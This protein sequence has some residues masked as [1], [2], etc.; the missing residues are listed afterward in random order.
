MKKLLAIVVLS[1][2]L[3]SESAFAKRTKW[4]R[5]NFYENEIFWT[6]KLK[7]TLPP[8][9]F[10]LVERYDWSSW[11]LEAKSSDL[12]SLKN[13]VFDQMVSIGEV[14]SWTYQSYVR[15]WIYEWLYQNKYDGCYQRSEYTV[16]EV[17]KKGSFHNCMI[18]RHYEIIKELYHPDDPEDI[19]GAPIKRWIENNNIEMPSIV[20]CSEHYFLAPSITNNLFSVQFCMNPETNGASKS[21]YSTEAASEYH[22]SNINQYPDKKKFMEK[23]IKLSAK[24][25]R[26]FE[27]GL[28][29]KEHHKMDLSKYGVVGGITEESKDISSSS[30]LTE[31]L[32]ELH[33][34]YKEGI[35]TK[36]EFEK[37]KKK[38]LSQ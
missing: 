1:L 33:E 15:Q 14:G 29:A 19:A 4:V 9:S 24:R 26:L 5:G 20:L 32:K 6:S 13:G 27:Q 17:K 25:H 16:V 3:F 34:L 2:I 10:Q 7:I 8:G 38:V 28:R 35:L 21:K 37:A 12:I 23:W 30:N 36:E 18:V 22:P 11:G 31:E